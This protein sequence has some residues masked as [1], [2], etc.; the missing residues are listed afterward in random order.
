M[1]TIRKCIDDF[2]HTLQVVLDHPLLQGLKGKVSVTNQMHKLMF[3]YF[4]DLVSSHTLPLSHYNAAE[5]EMRECL[6]QKVYSHN[7]SLNV[8][9]NII[10]RISSC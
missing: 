6:L 9:V 1:Y 8:I 3:N 4:V 5:W 10:D 2:R 7:D